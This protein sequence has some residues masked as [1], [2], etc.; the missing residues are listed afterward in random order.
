M[1]W[2]SP[3]KLSIESAE[4]SELSDLTPTQE[5]LLLHVME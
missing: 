3:K 5:V 1:P 2:A 4:D